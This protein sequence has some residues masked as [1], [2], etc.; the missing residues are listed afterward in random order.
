MPRLVISVI[1]TFLIFLAEMSSGIMCSLMFFIVLLS[2]L[3]FNKP[4]NFSIII[5]GEVGSV[6]DRIQLVHLLGKVMCI[7]MATI[8]RHK[9]KLISH[10]IH[11]NRAHIICIISLGYSMPRIQYKFFCLYGISIPSKL[12]PR[13][14][15][16]FFRKNLI[17]NER[18]SYRSVLVIFQI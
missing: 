6:E 3:Q 9:R 17:K 14:P 12:I 7:A 18:D 15:S 4:R 13:F 11:L 2:D 10:L 1:F 8:V 5:T 16:Q